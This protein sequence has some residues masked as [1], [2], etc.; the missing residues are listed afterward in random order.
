[1]KE[2]TEEH[3]KVIVNHF[4]RTVSQFGGLDGFKDLEG[5]MVGLFEEEDGWTLRNIRPYDRGAEKPVARKKLPEHF[6]DDLLDAQLEM[7]GFLS[8]WLRLSAAAKKGARDRGAEKTLKASLK[9][10]EARLA[11]KS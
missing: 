7:A 9:G 11:K 1:M 2:L 4:V 10:V 6:S 5:Q 8:V 3:I